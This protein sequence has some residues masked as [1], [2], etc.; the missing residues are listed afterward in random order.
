MDTKKSNV[1][2]G[3]QQKA[4]KGH[5]SAALGAGMT[6]ASVAG[7]T[8]GT[9]FTRKSN[10]DDDPEEALVDVVPEEEIA[11]ESQQ[12]QAVE[13]TSQDTTPA[14]EP[15]GNT[16]QKQPAEEQQK[17]DDLEKDPE[18]V[19]DRI[20]SEDDID[21]PEYGN[22]IHPVEMR[23]ITDADGNEVEAMI[24]ED[25][26]G[27]QFA[28]CQSDPGSGIFDKV[29]D[30]YTLESI[31]MPQE[32]S[33]TRTDFEELLH[34]DGSYIPPEPDGPMFA[35]N[36]DIS[37]DIKTT[38]DGEMVAQNE[39]TAQVEPDID[40]NIDIDDELEMSE[41]DEDLVAQMLNDGNEI[42]ED[43]VEVDGN[44]IELIE[45][46]F[47]DEESEEIED[48]VEFEEKDDEDFEDNEEDEDSE[49]DDDEEDEI[50]DDD[51]DNDEN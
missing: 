50:D 31:D 38:D 17:D 27:Y 35:D 33:Y 12:E 44:L 10:L 23:N 7:A 2:T 16:E 48:E 30:P 19:T 43:E 3:S 32:I 9:A 45:D 22:E 11:E 15:V 36:D 6:I 28:L 20:L 25:E 34:D 14:E 4:K 47:D 26:E 49:N 1:N 8:I 5:S 40:I 37:K 39:P 41:A 51:L 21:D 13:Q 42:N 46:I 18:D 29:V 24:F